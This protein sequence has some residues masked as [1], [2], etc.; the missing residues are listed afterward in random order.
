MSSPLDR[1]LSIQRDRKDPRHLHGCREIAAARREAV[2]S[3]AARRKTMMKQSDWQAVRD[4]LIADD[5]AKLGEPPTVEEILA[6]ER[7]ELSRE[8]ADRVQQLLI[9]YPELARAF[10]TP[11]PSADEDLP[12]HVVD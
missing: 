10:A 4:A 12:N 7:G 11:F 6:Y 2:S 1:R 3:R 9:A 5:R 8:D